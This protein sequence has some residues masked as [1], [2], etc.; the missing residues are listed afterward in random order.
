MGDSRQPLLGV[1]LRP[2]TA[3]GV[4]TRFGPLTWW[5]GPLNVEGL[6]L[7]ATHAFGSVLAGLMGTRHT[8]SFDSARVA[9]WFGSFS[10]LRVDGEPLSAFAPLSGFFASSDGWVRTHANYPH[11]ER[12]LLRA[13]DVEDGPSAA[14]AMRLMTSAQIE[15]AAQETGAIAV[16]VRQPGQVRSA[17]G[18]WI[19]ISEVGSARAFRPGDG[20][21][22]TGL[23]VLDLSRVIAGPSASRLLGALGADVLRIDPPHL[24]ELTSHHLDTG[25]AKRTAVVDLAD[26]GDRVRSLVD[27]A[28]VVFLGY[29][30]SSLE[31]TGFGPE[32]I[33]ERH[34]HVAVVSLDAWGE[35]P[36]WSGRRG[37]DSV[38]Q[39]ATGISHLYGTETDD[40]WRPGALP[41]Q[42]LDMATG[43]GMAAA[44][45][46]LA[47][48]GGRA[49]LSL[50]RT[51]RFLIDGGAAPAA[52]ED[53]LLTLRDMES[54]Y[55]L[56][57]YAPVPISIDGVAVDYPAPPLP[58]GDG[59]PVWM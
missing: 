10:H 3:P 39:A 51:A 32:A 15:E 8:I 7:S 59:E 44:A 38:V 23:R 47:G 57:T 14:A 13:L 17:S 53:V 5:G 20:A 56:L 31:R 22:L 43:L 2:F 48:R 28:D 4:C 30:L 55:G 26:E 21:P 33:A 42:A 40:G 34:P 54:A 16:A 11:H 52:P 12:A 24:P 37:F 25:F 41:V 29:R 6:A 49:H 58:Y 50:A 18:D 19:E 36:G 46:A 1:S 9:A 45:L 27:R 35:I